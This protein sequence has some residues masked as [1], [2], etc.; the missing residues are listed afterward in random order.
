MSDD[1]GEHEEEVFDI[2]QGGGDHGPYTETEHENIADRLQSSC[3]GICIGLLLFLGSFPLLFWNEGRAV[4]RYDALEEAKSR[5]A[6]VSG[7][8]IDPANEGRLLHFSVH[9][10]NGGA[11]G[12]LFDPIFGIGSDDG[13]LKLR[14]DAEMYQWI[15]RVDNTT[16]K[17]AGGGKTTT[18]TYNY[19]KQWTDRP[20]DSTSFKKPS[21]HANPTDMEFVSDTFVADPI[22]IGAYKL[23]RDLEGRVD[24]YVPLR[25][26]VENVTDPSIRSRAAKTPEG[27][28]YFG[29]SS[30]SRPRVGDQRVSFSEVPESVVTVVGVQDGETLAAFISETGEG[31]E[32]LLFRRGNYTA[33]AMF[34]AAEEENAAAT[35]LLRGVGFAVMAVGLYLVFRPIEVFADIIPC[36]GSIVGCGLVFISV[37]ISAILSSITISIA[38]LAARPEIGAIVLAV[39]LAVIGCCALGAKKLIGERNGKGNDDGSS[40]S[41]SSPEEVVAADAGP[42]VPAADAGPVVYPVAVP[43]V[44]TS[45][46]PAVYAMPEG[47]VV[48]ATAAEPEV[49]YSAGPYV[50]GIAS[51]DPIVHSSPE[52]YV[53]NY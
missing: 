42:A 28:L 50:P 32:V 52:T 15:E 23:P 8:D 27:G 40:F 22:M 46:A 26:E 31:G 48:T 16:S 19:E 43:T 5:V 2:E 14:R 33:A 1:G 7:L 35:W 36:V 38:W 47:S 34:D 25:V 30:S 24:W 53:P 45:A 18:K 21:G 37:L 6:S 10:T 39:S 20:V 4:E 49:N 13:S 11:G 12:G 41:T 17:K 44:Y 29:S 51:T 3:A 9:V